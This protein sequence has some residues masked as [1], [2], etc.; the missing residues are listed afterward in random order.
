[1]TLSG[2]YRCHDT[3]GLAFVS[4]VGAAGLRP[5]AARHRRHPAVCDG[6]STRG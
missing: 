2:T 1:M 6:L 5:R 3:S 4:V